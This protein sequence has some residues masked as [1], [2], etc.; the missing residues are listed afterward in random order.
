[1]YDFSFY[2]RVRFG[3]CGTTYS[4]MVQNGKVL[5]VLYNITIE[6]LGENVGFEE[7]YTYIFRYN[8]CIQRVDI[9]S[10][11]WIHHDGRIMSPHT[12]R[13]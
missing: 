4:R 2:L 6:S 10:N 5:Y 8:V 9:H 7:N 11:T 1:M 3:Y 13:L 12:D